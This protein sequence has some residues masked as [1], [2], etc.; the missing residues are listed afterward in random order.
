M[1]TANTEPQPNPNALFTPELMGFNNTGFAP[2]ADIYGL[3]DA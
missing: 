2:E 3:G 1:I